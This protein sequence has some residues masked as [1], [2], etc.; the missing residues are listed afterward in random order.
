M[1]EGTLDVIGACGV[2][3]VGAMPDEGCAQRQACSLRAAHPAC[4]LALTLALP[5][6]RPRRP[7]CGLLFGRCR[8]SCSARCAD[9]PP[10]P[11]VPAPPCRPRGGVQRQPGGLHALPLHRGRHRQRHGLLAVGG[12]ERPVPQ[13]AGP[14]VQVCRPA[15]VC[16]LGPWRGPGLDSAGLGMGKDRLAG[17]SRS[18]AGVQAG[19][20]RAGGWHSRA[21]GGWV[22][23]AHGQVSIT[24]ARRAPLRATSASRAAPPLCT[25]AACFPTSRSRPTSWCSPTTR[26][27]RS[28]A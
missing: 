8:A 3:C 14:D 6:A 23:A 10:S 15:V 17:G 12:A 2:C 19:G 16:S 13:E 11:A 26:C 5:P 18:C 21:V 22:R 28:S 20:R 4:L 24:P 25:V 7:E 1:Q 9:P 27:S